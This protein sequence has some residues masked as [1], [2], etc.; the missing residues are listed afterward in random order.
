MYAMVLPSGETLVG[1]RMLFGVS[2]ATGVPALPDETSNDIAYGVTETST[3]SKAI[4]VPF[5]EKLGR[6][7][8]ANTPETTGSGSP[9]ARPVDSSTATRQR[10]MTPPRSLEKYTYLPSGDQT[11]DQ[12]MAAS[13]VSATRAPPA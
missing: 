7:S 13:F 2:V 8:F 3:A 9:A 6:P 5:L 12:S 1:V 10:F 11:G 4:R